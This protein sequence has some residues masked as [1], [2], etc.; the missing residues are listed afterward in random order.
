MEILENYLEKI[1]LEYNFKVLLNP[2][3]NCLKWQENVSYYLDKFRKVY[4]TSTVRSIQ[5]QRK[6]INAILSFSSNPGCMRCAT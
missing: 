1:D 2:I 6:K 5:K 3:L 4:T